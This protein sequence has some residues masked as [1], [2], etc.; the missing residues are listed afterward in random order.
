MLLCCWLC[1][2]PRQAAPPS[3]FCMK[4]SLP[5]QLKSHSHLA[6]MRSKQGLLATAVCVFKAW[7]VGYCAMYMLAWLH[8]APQPSAT[9]L[10]N[11]AVCKSRPAYKHS[12]VGLALPCLKSAFWVFKLPCKIVFNSTKLP[13]G[14]P[15]ELFPPAGGTT[16]ATAGAVCGGSMDSRLCKPVPGPDRYFPLQAVHPALHRTDS[17]PQLQARLLRAHHLSSAESLEIC[18]ECVFCL[19]CPLPSRVFLL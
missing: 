10:I 19:L 9:E 18:L 4:L 16:G 5:T 17:L 7:H 8:S 12:C 2:L 11:L 6:G 15:S 1:C 14:F 13:S 3:I